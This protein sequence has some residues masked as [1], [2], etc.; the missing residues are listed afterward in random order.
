M[1]A[2]TTKISELKPPKADTITG[3][4]SSVTI[5]D[6]FLLSDNTGDISVNTKD[7]ATV[8][9]DYLMRKF[10]VTGNLNS[11]DE[12]IPIDIELA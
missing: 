9:K 1:M 7:F 12:F 5:P 6:K 2:R 10:K 8:T 11:R 4:V 3:I